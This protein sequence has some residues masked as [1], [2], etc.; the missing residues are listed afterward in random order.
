MVNTSKCD[1][2]EV[3]CQFSCNWSGL[4]FIISLVDNDR[5]HD[6]EG[7]DGVTVSMMIRTCMRSLYYG[8]A[9]EII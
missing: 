7:G 5:D 9:N 6:G 8:C 2:S 1:N 3:K 4:T